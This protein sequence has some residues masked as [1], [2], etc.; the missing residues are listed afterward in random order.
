MLLKRIFDITVA[1]IGIVV[2]SPLLI[3]IAFLLKL[4]SPRGRIL[5][6]GERVGRYGKRFRLLKFRTM[7]AHADSMG[8]P[9]TPDGDPRVTHLGR[10]LRKYKLDEL[11]QLWNVLAGQMSFVGPRPEVPQYA[12]LLTEQEQDVLS[13]R[14][15]ITDWASLWNCDEGAA[16]AGSEDPERTYLEKIRPV[17]VALQ[18]EYVRSQS[19]RTDLAILFRTIAALIFRAKQPSYL[20]IQRPTSFHGCQSE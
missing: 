2:L 8:G 18:L 17:K 10:V 19:F 13:V 14:P 11:P 6:S 3:S 16:L 12:S 1:M 15:G 9:S 20:A 4:G 5:Y 7:V